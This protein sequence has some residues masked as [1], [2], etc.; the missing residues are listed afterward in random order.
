MPHKTGRSHVYKP[1]HESS[2][3]LCKKPKPLFFRLVSLFILK[4]INHKM[5]FV[6]DIQM[7]TVV[8]TGQRRMLF[9]WTVL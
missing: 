2:L 3:L 8:T 5:I 9:E 7:E 4:V 1:L 6:L